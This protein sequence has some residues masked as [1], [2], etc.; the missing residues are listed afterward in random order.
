MVGYQ[1]PKRD[2]LPKV[3]DLFP[4][5]FPKKEGTGATQPTTAEEY[6]KR[7]GM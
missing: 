5:Y 4:S 6:L 2:P 7:K 3:E 1:A